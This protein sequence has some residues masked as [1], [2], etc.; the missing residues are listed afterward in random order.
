MNTRTLAALTAGILALGLSACGSDDDQ[1]PADPSMTVSVSQ[2]GPAAEGITDDMRNNRSVTTGPD[3][4][5]TN[6]GSEEDRAQVF[7]EWICSTGKNAAASIPA[8]SAATH[9]LATSSDPEDKKIALDIMQKVQGADAITPEVPLSIA[10]DGDA[11]SGWVWDHYLE[12]QTETQYDAF[13]AEKANQLG[14][15]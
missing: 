15:I 3:G 1:D 14:L 9:I 4:T 2:D 5:F 12:S 6:F 7:A 13:T 8:T 10:P 11:C